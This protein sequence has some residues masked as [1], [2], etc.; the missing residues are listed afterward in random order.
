MLL[1][2]PPSQSKPWCNIYVDTLTAYKGIK[3]VGDAEIGNREEF[4]ISIKEAVSDDAVGDVS[5]AFIKSGN[6]VTFWIDEFAHTIPNANAA[7]SYVS[8]GLAVPVDMIPTYD[9]YFPII[10]KNNGEKTPGTLLIS[11]QGEISIYLNTITEAGGVYTTNCL[12]D[13]PVNFETGIEDIN[14]TYII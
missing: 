8:D 5:A 14:A 6:V 1:E 4:D 9:T 7:S 3:L 2:N 11:D 13:F 12:G 10:V